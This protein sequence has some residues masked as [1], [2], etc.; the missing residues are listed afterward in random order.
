MPKALKS[1]KKESTSPAATEP[2]KISEPLNDDEQAALSAQHEQDELEAQKVSTEKMEK[3]VEV[4]QNAFN[5]SNGS[6]V[7]NGF[8]SKGSKCQLSL[9]NDDF[10][11]VITI[12][13]T[14]K[15]D[16]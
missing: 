10:D 14:E 7:V 8:A 3:A 6:F 5:L 16:I 9:S 12:K 11:L 2:V 13:D 4:C 15:F 1:K